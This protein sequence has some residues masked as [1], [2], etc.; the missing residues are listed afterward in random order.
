MILNEKSLAKMK[1]DLKRVLNFIQTINNYYI[2][3]TWFN[4]ADTPHALMLNSN[5]IDERIL[6]TLK[7]RSL[8]L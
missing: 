7:N 1:W 3:Q 4:M 6:I 2:E 5:I 8:K